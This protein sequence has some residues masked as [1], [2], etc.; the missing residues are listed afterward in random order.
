ML[1]DKA[2][3]NAISGHRKLILR[4]NNFNTFPFLSKRQR[5]S[6]FETFGDLNAIYQASHQD[7]INVKYI[8]P[9]TANLLIDYIK[10]TS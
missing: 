4:E 7:I 2:H 10:K 3:S 6:L 5:E 9:K 8:G 1:R